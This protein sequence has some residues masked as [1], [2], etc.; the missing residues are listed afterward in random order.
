MLN[1]YVKLYRAFKKW[2]WYK[3]QNTKDV[4]LDL[5]LNANH[6][7]GRFKGYTIE[8]GQLAVALGTLA[9]RTGLT[10]Q[11]VRTSLN[12]LKSTREITS[13]ATS[14]FLIITLSNWEEYQGQESST[15]TQSNT[16]S[17]TQ[18]TRNQHAI[19]NEVRREED[20]KILRESI[21]GRVGGYTDDCVSIIMARQEFSSLVPEHIAQE[22]A[23]CQGDRTILVNQFVADTANMLEAPKNP[24]GYLRGYVRRQAK[25][26]P[27]PLQE[28]KSARESTPAEMFRDWDGG[29]PKS[30]FKASYGINHADFADHLRVE[31]ADMPDGEFGQ[32]YRVRAV[33]AREI[34]NAYGY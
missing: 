13:R 18:S 28:G 1:G 34:I 9:E 26:T 27:T 30:K 21:R 32:K 19:N 12:K 17:N 4:F 2:E 7:P 5:L 10:V 31:L 25:E 29:V 8:A 24:I 11:M 3:D 23:L 20:K 14:R 15:N 6:E 22:L 33:E 16:E